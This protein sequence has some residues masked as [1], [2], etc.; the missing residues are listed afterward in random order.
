M[1]LQQIRIGAVDNA[2]Q[3]NDSD[4][5]SA[6]ETDQPIKAGIPIDGN[7]VIRLTDFTTHSPTYRQ[8]TIVHTDGD[9]T[10]SVLSAT[11]IIIANSLPTTIT[12]FDDGVDGQE[13][14][15]IFSD[16][17]TVIDTSNCYLSGGLGFTSSQYDPLTL[18]NYSSKWYEKS[19]SVNA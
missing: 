10:P 8:Q 18:I 5:D 14:T 16:G 11:Y 13:I 9:T 1:A 3:Y 17:N 6:I 19:R 7:D 15:L 12:N 2:A 4:Y